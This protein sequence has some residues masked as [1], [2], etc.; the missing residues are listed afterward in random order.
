MKLG[1]SNEN[2]IY[3]LFFF[4]AKLII[5]QKTLVFGVFEPF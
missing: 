4:F 1:Q 5:P 3:K 2:K